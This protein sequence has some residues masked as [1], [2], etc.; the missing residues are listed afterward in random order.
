MTKGPTTAMAM[1][2]HARETEAEGHTGRL[3]PWGVRPT[4]VPPVARPVPA[5]V[6]AGGA[7]LGRASAVGFVKSSFPL[8]TNGL[9]FCNVAL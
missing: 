4:R 1:R 2:G 3:T 6:A 9:K 7:T 8:N 5:I